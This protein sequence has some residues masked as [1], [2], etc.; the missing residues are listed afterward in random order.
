MK[1][2]KNITFLILLTFLVSCSMIHKLSCNKNI[3]CEKHPILLEE[4]KREFTHN[5]NNADNYRYK[6]FPNEDIHYGNILNEDVFTDGG[7][8]RVG[9]IV[10]GYKEGKWISGDAGFDEN[11]NVVQKAN[12]WREEYF[13]KGLRDSVFRQFDKNHKMI[14]ETN[15]KS[16]TGLWKEFH[17]NGKLYFEIATQDGYFRDTLKL[18]SDT[19]IVFQKRLYKKDVLVYYLDNDWCL[20]YR[21]QPN[22]STYL[23]VDSYDVKNLKQE[24]FRNTFRY[25]NKEEYDSD[26]FAKTRLQKM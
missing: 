5:Y 24:T 21:Y 13:K 10:N 16:G 8:H 3:A 7:Q 26:D 15:F 2:L 17:T 6:D 22:D 14:Y 4:K 11:E 18:H 1:C 25:K 20:R 19:G 12:I 9:K 23:E